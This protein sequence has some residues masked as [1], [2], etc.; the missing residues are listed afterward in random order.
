MESEDIAMLYLPGILGDDFR[1]RAGYVSGSAN[2][3]SKF[4][5]RNGPTVNT[6][7]PSQ[8]LVRANLATMSRLWRNV[9]PQNQLTWKV[10]ADKFPRKNNLGMTYHLTA[11]QMF[12]F[13]NCNLINAGQSYLTIAPDI[14]DNSFNALVTPNFYF[15]SSVLPYTL[16]FSVTTSPT[17]VR[18]IIIQSTGV[19]SSGISYPKGFKTIYSGSNDTAIPTNLMS[20]YLTIFGNAPKLNDTVFFRF[21]LYDTTTG[22]KSMKLILKALW[23][24]P[25]PP[26]V[27]PS[28]LL[29]HMNGTNGSTVFI[30]SSNS[31]HHINVVPPAVIS[32]LQSKFGGTSGYFDGTSAALNLL[33]DLDFDFGTGD[34][35]I[36]FWAY[37]TQNSGLQGF[38][39]FGG[40][41]AQYFPEIFLNNPNSGSIY[42]QASNDGNEWIIAEGTP[43]TIPFYTWNHIAV[44]RH[45]NSI[46]IYLNGTGQLTKPFNGN[47]FNNL[48]DLMQINN[49]RGGVY[50]Y[51]GYMNEF[52][53]VK[54]TAIWT[55]NFSPP[56]SP[57]A[58]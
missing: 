25:P 44:V 15:D 51:K 22:F 38:L 1:G 10:L 35:T 58:D 7:K 54:G 57:Y 11:F 39:G 27:P 21:W 30:D 6:K 46:T 41:P 4:L 50:F 20:Y 32:N 9:S 3:N 14:L 17:P 5:R 53:I 55:S 42:L 12:M 8:T 36:D 40:S 45:G 16:T 47:F 18:G 19:M 37:P 28:V 23:A 26:P 56:T 33:Q 49:Y 29:L 34:F 43:A 2:S 48:S 13:C 52:H 31:H 24:T